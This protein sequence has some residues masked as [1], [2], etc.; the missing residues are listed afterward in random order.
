MKKIIT[1]IG[2][3]NRDMVFQTPYFPRPGETITARNFEM[4]SGGKGAN[5]AVA[6]SRLGGDVFFITKMGNDE[7]ENKSKDKFSKDGIRVNYIL[8]DSDLPSGTAVIM[9]ND[10]GQNCI[11]ITPGANDN[12][13]SSDIDACSHAIEKASFV[14]MQLEIPYNTV[15]HALDISYKMKKKVI[16]NPAPT[17]PLEDDIYQKLYLIT[18]NQTEATLLTGIEVENAKSASKAADIFLKKGVQNVIITLGE[19]GAYFKN[20]EEQFLVPIQEVE[21][22]DTTGAGDIF[23]GALVVA[24]SE[25]KNWRQAVEFANSA[26]SI[27]VSRLGAQSSA[28]YRNEISI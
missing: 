24:L 13:L 21:V 2:S 5:Q 11:V 27:G 7:L 9:V 8:Q 25:G 1:V 10:N 3:Y 26:S 22:K 18:P 19:N 6:A 14:L 28:P 4:F 20:N 17:V 15:K 12:L 23:N 16:L